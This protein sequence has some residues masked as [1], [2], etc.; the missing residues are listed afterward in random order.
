MVS[1]TEKKNSKE[2]DWE[3]WDGGMEAIL[4][5]VVRKSHMERTFKQRIHGEEGVSHV[6]IRFPD[7]KARKPKG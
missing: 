5:R 3:I 7:R 1:V 2:G 6:D 4:N